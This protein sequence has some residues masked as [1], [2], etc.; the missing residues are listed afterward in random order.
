MISQAIPE[1]M[2]IMIV[3]ITMG[4]TLHVNTRYWLA[5]RDSQLNAHLPHNPVPSAH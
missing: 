4:I 1:L 2:Y 3:A 5:R